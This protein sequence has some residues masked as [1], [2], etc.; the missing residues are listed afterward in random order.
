MEKEEILESIRALFERAALSDKDKKALLQ[1]AVNENWPGLPVWSTLK[2]PVIEEVQ[3]VTVGSGILVTFVDDDGVRKAVMGEAGPHYKPTEFSVTIPG[4]FINLTETPGSAKVEP[5]KDPEDAFIGAAREIEEEFKLPGGAP[6]LTVDP[7]R[8]ELADT[9]TIVLPW[10]EHRVVIGLTLELNREEAAF[11]KA[12][13]SKLE[14]DPAYKAAAAAESINEASGKPELASIQIIPLDD[15]AGGK[16]NLL[17]KDQL[18]LF[19]AVQRHF[20]PKVASLEARPGPT[21]AYLEKV[22]TL[23]QLENLAEEWRKDGGAVV[24]VTSGVFDIL[25]PGH[26]SFFNDA[27]ARCDKLV[28]IIASDRTV[29]EQKGEEKP[30]VD[31]IKRAQT[32]AAIGTVDAVIISDEYYHESILGALCADVFFKGD[33]YA[34][35]DIKGSELVGRVELIPCAEKEFYSSSAFAQKIQRAGRGKNVG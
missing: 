30:Y 20:A 34:G 26:I 9:K 31:E 32:A 23:D 1:Q 7:S 33:D 12:H 27:R 16:V 24:G 15:L 2:S 11:V 35:K 22:K 4:G 8:L 18:S 19:Q 14:S 5:S 6:L 3:K 28:V 25:H 29:R 10:G 21:R 17:H 13:V